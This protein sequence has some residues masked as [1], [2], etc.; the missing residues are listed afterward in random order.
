M[1]KMLDS[2]FIPAEIRPNKLELEPELDDLCRALSGSWARLSGRV[3]RLSA[4]PS[5]PCT[6]LL[7]PWEKFESSD[8]Q[9]PHL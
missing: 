8:P 4:G 9:Y 6:L 5:S 1:Q 2:N 3:E 7:L